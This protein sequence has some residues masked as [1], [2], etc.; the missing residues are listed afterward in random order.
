MTLTFRKIGFLF[1]LGFLLA[2]W[3]VGIMAIIVA[4][5]AA[6]FLLDIF[7]YQFD[8]K[9]KEADEDYRWS[10]DDPLGHWEA[11]KSDK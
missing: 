2:Y 4:G 5:I 9:A 7:T 1:C 11:H 8:T 10:Q 3:H 6:N